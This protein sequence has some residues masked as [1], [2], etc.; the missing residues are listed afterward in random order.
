MGYFIG[1]EEKAF[2]VEDGKVWD[3][4]EKKVQYDP[5]TLEPIPVEKEPESPKDKPVAKDPEQPDSDEIAELKAIRRE[6]LVSM[7]WGKLRK[8]HKSVTGSDERNLKKAE[9]IEG[10]I[11]QEF[12]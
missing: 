2:Y 6:E 11:T 4:P 3:T 8:L 9:I 12:K 1:I 7:Q 5:E 10:I